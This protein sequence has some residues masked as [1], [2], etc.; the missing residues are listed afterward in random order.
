MRNLRKAVHSDA[1]SQEPYSYSY[2]QAVLLPS[3][4]QEFHAVFQPEYAYDA[5]PHRREVSLRHMSEGVHH[6]VQPQVAQTC[7]QQRAALQVR[8]LPEEIRQRQQ[9]T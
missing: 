8:W 7:A 9:T 2:G 3:L 4:R 6:E 1:P 5:N